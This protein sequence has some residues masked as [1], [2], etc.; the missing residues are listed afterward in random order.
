MKWLKSLVDKFL[1]ALATPGEHHLARR[2]PDPDGKKPS[3]EQRLL[4]HLRK[5]RSAKTR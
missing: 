3:Y 2:A 5:Q 4:A 1:S